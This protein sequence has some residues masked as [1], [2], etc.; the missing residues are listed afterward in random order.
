[1]RRV[2]ILLLLMLAS[3]VVAQPTGEAAAAG[4]YAGLVRNA[5]RMECHRT[6]FALQD[7][8][9][10]GHYWIEGADPFE[11]E[12][13]DFKPQ[14]IGGGVAGTFIWTDRYGTGV[15]FV[16]FAND[17][18][19]FT[20]AWGDTSPTAGNTVWGTRAPVAGCDHAVS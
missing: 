17:A 19:S 5:G 15:E 10:V 2:A 4:S 20:G 1:M 6:V 16:L 8:R 13:T 3:P 7:G 18:A 9:L 12:L 14:A 11:G